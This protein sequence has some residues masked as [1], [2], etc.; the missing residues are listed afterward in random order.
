MVDRALVL[1]LVGVLSKADNANSSTAKNSN[2]PLCIQISER[3]SIQI[4]KHCLGE[5]I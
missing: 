4:H 2:K 5:G 3:A 1:K